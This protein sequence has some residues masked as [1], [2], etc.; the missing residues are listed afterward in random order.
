MKHGIALNAKK[1]IV[2]GTI[3]WEVKKIKDSMITLITIM[4][5]KKNL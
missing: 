1:M 5:K 2:S 3:P 4:N